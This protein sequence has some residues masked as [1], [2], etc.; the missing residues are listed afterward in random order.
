MTLKELYQLSHFNYLYTY[1][2]KF[3]QTSFWQFKLALVLSV[4]VFL[5]TYPNYLDILTDPSPRTTFDYFFSK[6]E[7]PFA[8]AV[9]G[10]TGSHGAKIAFRLTIPLLAKALRIGSTVTGKDVVLIFIIQSLLLLPFLWGFMKVVNRHLDNVSTVLAV[11]ACSATYLASAFFWDYHFWF[12]AYAFFFLLMG[13]FFRNRIAI[14]TFLLLACFTDERAVIALLS[15]Y[16]FHLLE[17][18]NFTLTGFRELFPRSILSSRASVVVLVVGTYVLV[19][20]LLTTTF[21]LRTPSGENVGVSVSIIPFQL[22]HRLIGILFSFEGF[23][24]LF[25]MSIVLLIVNRQRLLA[26]VLLACLLLHIVVAYSVYDI[27]RSLTYGFPLFITALLITGKG[28]AKERKHILAVVLLCC[29]VVPT[30]YVIYHIIQIPWTIT[31][32]DE[33]KLVVQSL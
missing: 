21:S 16:I 28:L 27:T 33:L 14:F 26:G 2:E 7:A 30:H 15:V 23:W 18:R 6:S 32:W 1:I 11:T 3:T 9:V 12:D 24:I 13:M 31:A 5:T 8:P 4:F 29:L 10:H 22:K 25:G 17:E 20:L 19:R